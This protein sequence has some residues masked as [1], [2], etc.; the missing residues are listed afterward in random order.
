MPTEI[1]S[2]V[3]IFRHGAGEPLVL[4]HGLGT[5]S[6]SWNPILPRLCAVHD[7]LAV[8][9]PG[10]GQSPPLPAGVEPTP[11]ALAD[12]VERGLDAAGVGSAHLCGNS[13]GG[14]VA[15]ELARRGRARSVVAISPAGFWSGPERVYA[16]ASLRWAHRRARALR[17]VARAAMSVRPLRYGLFAQVRRRPGRVSGAEAAH[18]VQMIAR[19]PEFPVTRETTLDGRRADSLAG[20]SSPV[21]VLWGTRDLLLPVSQA[22]RAVAAIPGAQLRRLR[23]LGHMPMADDPDAVADAILAWTA[24][25]DAVPAAVA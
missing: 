13:L 17:P 11:A 7:V 12:A 1:S 10:F 24:R 16:L 19:R 21:L 22:A 2:P 3:R 8:D 5:S 6:V 14:W 25:Q 20:L 4:I 23:G 9:L 18:E 15:L